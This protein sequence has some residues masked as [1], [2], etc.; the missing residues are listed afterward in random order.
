MKRHTKARPTYPPGAWKPVRRGP[1]YCAPACGA[2]CTYAA[3]LKAT[4]LA[5]LMAA[6]LGT[7]WKPRVWENM[8]W[9]YSAVATFAD[10]SRAEIYPGSRPGE[11]PWCSL[12]AGGERGRQ[13]HANG[14]T[15]RAA[16]MAVVAQLETARDAAVA[17]LESIRGKGR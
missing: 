6:K 7:R 4:R 14:R 17:A 8:G 13:F 12:H 10:G 5:A 2:G 11:R 1:V 9:H 16:L 15:P 3:F